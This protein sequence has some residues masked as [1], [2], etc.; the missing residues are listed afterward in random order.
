MPIK[1]VKS[2]VDAARTEITIIPTKQVI[3]M[4][5]DPDV[6][7][8]DIRDIRELDRDGR[9]PGAFHAPRGMLEFWV[10]PQSPYHKPALSAGKKMIFFCASAWRSALTVKT[11]QDMGVTNI[12]DLEGGFTAWRAAGGPIDKPEPRG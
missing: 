9:I 6:M 2:L 3:A 10:D 4:M 12:F 1:S 7:L 8:V 11:L 5:N